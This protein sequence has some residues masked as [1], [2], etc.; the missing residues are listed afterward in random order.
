MRRLNP[1]ARSRGD[2][3]STM[4]PIGEMLPTYSVNVSIVI[5][6]TQC[7]S[8]AQPRPDLCDLLSSNARPIG[9]LPRAL[10]VR[11][12][13]DRIERATDTH[14]HSLVIF[15]TT[16]A[17][18]R[19]NLMLRACGDVGLV[20]FF[21]PDY[22]NSIAYPNLEECPQYFA[23]AHELG[24][25]ARHHYLLQ[26]EIRLRELEADEWAGRALAELRMPAASVDATLRLLA[27]PL[28][29]T[30]KYPGYCD[31]FQAVASGY[32]D[33]MQVTGGPLL[34][35]QYM[36]SLT[37]EIVPKTFARL[38]TIRHRWRP[39]L[40]AIVG[41]VVVLLTALCCAFRYQRRR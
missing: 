29:S 32:N 1:V 33:A 18:V 31:R 25:I 17:R 28:Q 3:G 20:L 12:I 40:L 2:A 27:A 11:H 41:G 7:L 30:A 4:V 10:E 24:H 13:I 16:D 5:F 14:H 15:P 19:G 6:A 35:P 36:C 37:S 39:I 38:K 21:D 22:F 34:T 9:P 23:V 26:T 8:F